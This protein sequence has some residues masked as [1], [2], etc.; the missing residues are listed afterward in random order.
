MAA[1]LN[2]AYTRDEFAFYMEDLGARLLIIARAT[3]PSARR[4]RRSGHP[5]S[6]ELT[7]GEAAGDF[8]LVDVAPTADARTGNGPDDVALVLHTSGTTS[9][10]KIVPLTR[11]NVGRLGA[12]HRGDAAR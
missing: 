12:Q 1:P 7:T 2:P 4:G 11:P 10:P 6:L 5:R 3:T 9:R 8:A